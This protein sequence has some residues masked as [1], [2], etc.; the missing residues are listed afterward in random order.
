MEFVTCCICGNRVQQSNGIDICGVCVKTQG[1]RIKILA[2]KKYLD[3]YPEATVQDVL[4]NLAVRQ[5]D[6]DRYVKEGSVRLIYSKEGMKVVNA[7]KEEKEFKNS[8][9]EDRK[10]QVISE[11]AKAYNPYVGK[12]RNIKGTKKLQ[13]K[14]VYDLD[15]RFN[16]NQKGESR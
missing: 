2:I 5:S 8:S 1:D 3:I 4:K 15:R 14:L 12:D 11:L 6:I 13:S 10:K 7:K 9:E 16:N